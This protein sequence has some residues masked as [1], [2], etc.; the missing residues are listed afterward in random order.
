[1]IW[2]QPGKAFCTEGTELAKDGRRESAWPLGITVE[3]IE[4]W[5][6]WGANVSYG[7]RDQAGPSTY[8]FS[9]WLHWSSLHSK[10]LKGLV[11]VGDICDLEAS[12]LTVCVW[13]G[14]WNRQRGEQLLFRSKTRRQLLEDDKKWL[15][16][17]KY[18]ALFQAS[19]ICSL[20]LPTTCEIGALSFPIYR[21]GIG[22]KGYHVT[23]L[24]FEC[25]QCGSNSCAFNCQA[26]FP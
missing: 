20:V 19:Y 4:F 12:L 24:E 18:F 2:S 23:R 9:F 21:W 10:L 26:L 25:S 3:E 5:C 14:S 11:W 7:C 15:M 13:V 1:M 6:G 22:G 17:T 8:W 16:F